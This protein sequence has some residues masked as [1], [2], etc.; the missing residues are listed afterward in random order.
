MH[1]RNVWLQKL[2][3]FYAEIDIWTWSKEKGSPHA[4]VLRG[5]S[6]APARQTEVG[7]ERVTN[8]WGCLRGRLG[9]RNEACESI[10]EWNLPR[11]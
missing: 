7:Q 8:R 5:S 9:E 1:K 11:S 10:L 3:I 4:N 6:R 2:K